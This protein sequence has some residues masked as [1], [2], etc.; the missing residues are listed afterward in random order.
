NDHTLAQNP[1]CQEGQCFIGPNDPNYYYSWGE[2]SDIGLNYD[3]LCPWK[4][5]RTTRYIGS[6]PINENQI[7]NVAST[8][9]GME[10]MWL[11]TGD[12]PVG[13]GNWVVEAPC[14]RDTAGNF[15]IPA[16]LSWWYSYGG[17]DTNP[18][19]HSWLQYGGAWPYHKVN[20]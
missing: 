12:S 4:D 2:R 20:G 1:N 8:I 3:Y 14:D 9:A 15:L 18:A 17:W 5:D 11:R 6:Q 13:G 10:T 19:D 7:G 16:D